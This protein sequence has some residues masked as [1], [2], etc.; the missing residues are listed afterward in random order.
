VAGSW[1]YREHKPGSTFE[2]SL[3]PAV[4]ERALASG[5]IRLLE[6]RTPSIQPGTYRLPVGWA[7]PHEEE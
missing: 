5:A 7:T 1:P 3:D 2:A 6:R 4:E